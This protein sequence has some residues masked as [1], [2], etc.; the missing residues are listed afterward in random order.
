MSSGPSIASGEIKSPEHPTAEKRSTRSSTSP[1]I[2]N[3]TNS[4]HPKYQGHTQN[5]HDPRYETTRCIGFTALEWE[6]V[7]RLDL[8][9]DGA[10][11]TCDRCGCIKHGSNELLIHM[12]RRRKCGSYSLR[13]GDDDLL[14]GA[15]LAVLGAVDWKTYQG[16]IE[17]Y[18][19]MWEVCTNPTPSYF[20][21]LV[22]LELESLLTSVI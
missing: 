9:Y 19:G 7:T 12:L 11:W 20:C 22:L 21:R 17:C 1:K 8:G 18:V 2:G 4:S 15:R 16:T 5:G 14:Y 13:A 3:T 6:I 10:V